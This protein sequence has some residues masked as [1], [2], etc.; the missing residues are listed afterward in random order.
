MQR[1]LSPLAPLSLVHE[2]IAQGWICVLAQSW[3]RSALVSTSKHSAIGLHRLIEQ[4]SRLVSAGA[5]SLTRQRIA[6]AISVQA[7]YWG[8]SALV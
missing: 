8:R 7:Q 5:L 4:C 1:P 2:R 3:G 6:Q